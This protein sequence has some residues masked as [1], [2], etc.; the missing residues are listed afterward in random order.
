MSVLVPAGENC[1]A[2]GRGRT[3]AEPE[4]GPIA[5]PELGPDAELELGPNAGP[6]L[7]P[8][9]FCAA[10]RCRSN[11]GFTAFA[12]TLESCCGNCALCC[13]NSLSVRINSS[14]TERAQVVAEVVGVVCVVVNVTIAAPAG[15]GIVRAEVIW[16]GFLNVF[17][18]TRSIHAAFSTMTCC[19]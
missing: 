2:G 9:A 3:L 8:N 19:A 7:E 16:V 15:V 13:A 1:V 6:E 14:L 18:A 4:W 11:N 17:F 12:N 10:V 5:G